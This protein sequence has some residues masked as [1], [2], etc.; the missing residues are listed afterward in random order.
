MS[1]FKRL[2]MVGI[3]LSLMVLVTLLVI[4]ANSSEG[5]ASVN[6]LEHKGAI[7]VSPADD[8][9]IPQ[10]NFE[11][12]GITIVSSSN[13]FVE[14]YNKGL[15][16][17]KIIYFHPQ[18]F[19]EISPEILQNLYNQH[20]LLVILGLPASQVET[21]LKVDLNIPDLPKEVYANGELITF[22]AVLLTQKDKQGE[23]QWV[24]ADFL[25]P[26]SF[27]FLFSI[28]ETNAKELEASNEA[29]NLST[30]CTPAPTIDLKTGSWSVAQGGNLTGLGWSDKQYD[31]TNHMDSYG[32][33]TDV[34]YSLPRAHYLRTEIQVWNNC[35]YVHMISNRSQVIYDG[36]SICN[37]KTSTY[38][39]SCSQA[40]FWATSYHSG[41]HLVSTQSTTGQLT[42]IRLWP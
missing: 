25:S 21:T 11:N 35:T 10:T 6:Y 26:E 33:H 27:S 24:Y 41:K 30:N 16:N 29:S 37:I 13:T 23:G 19:Q 3:G 22:V 34:I 20:K 38:P 18:A 5:E 2:F 12:I 36:K 8:L 39:Q 7:F 1:L 14:E 9:L 42:N 17:S 4:P 28:I 32:A 40:N 15:E 31:S